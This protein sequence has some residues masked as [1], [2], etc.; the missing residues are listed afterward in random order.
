[1]RLNYTS[2]D[3]R[4]ETDCLNP[5]SSKRDIMMLASENTPSEHPYCYAR[6]LGIF[7]ANVIYTG[8]GRIDYLPRRV[9][10][11]WVWWFDLQ[12]PALSW[13]DY[14]LDKGR[15]VP[16][17]QPHAFGFVDPDDVLRCCH[18]IPS[19]SDGRLHS[20]LSCEIIDGE[21]WKSYCVNR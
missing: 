8:P 18:L 17:H 9:E 6:V 21:L 1:M 5:R 13:Q 15:F 20:D 14:A 10:F 3:L 19:F 16:M 2:Y 11:L 7:H 12:C 4:R